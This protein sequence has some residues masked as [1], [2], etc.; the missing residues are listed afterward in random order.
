MCTTC[1]KPISGRGVNGICQR[2]L[3]I[4]ADMA[5]WNPS[6]PPQS[7]SIAGAIPRFEIG[8]P[9]GQGGMGV[10]YAATNKTIDV[11]VW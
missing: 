5:V 2:C 1:G 11:A 6:D 9:I 4:P 10:V 7:E 3:L 8:E